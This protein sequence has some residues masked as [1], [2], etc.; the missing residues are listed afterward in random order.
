MRKAL[1]AAAVVMGTGVLILLVVVVI[2]WLVS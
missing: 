1:D 2:S